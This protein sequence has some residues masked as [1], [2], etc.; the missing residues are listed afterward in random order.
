MRVRPSL[1]GIKEYKPGKLVKGAIKLSSNENPLGPSSDVL[2]EIVSSLEKGELDL[3][4]YPWE[5]NEE[6][7]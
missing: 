3:S 7:L 2:K 6:S 4:I 1:K 5:K